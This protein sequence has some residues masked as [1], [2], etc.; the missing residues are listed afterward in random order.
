[1]DFDELIILVDAAIHENTQ[2]H[3]RDAE[4]LVLRGSWVGQGYEEIAEAHHYTTQYLRQ[5]VG[6]KLWKLLSQVIGEKVSKTSFRSALERYGRTH[7]EP[8]TQA[9]EQG[10]LFPTQPSEAARNAKIRV[11]APSQFPVQADWGDVIDVSV[12]YGRAEELKTLVQWVVGDRCRLI[13][14]L[15]MGGIGKTSLSVRL[16][17]QIQ[18]QFEFV[19]WRSLRNAPAFEDLLGS[20]IHFLSSQQSA[21]L[22][23]NQDAQ[24]AVLLDYL[25]QHRCLIVLD[26]WESVLM[27]G[28]AGA[29]N[30][31]YEAYGQLLRCVA[32]AQHQSCIMITSREKPK[33]LS[34]REGNTLPVRSLALNGLSQLDAFALF[35]D[36]GFVNIEPKALKEVLQHYGGNPLALKIVAAAVEDLADCNL[37]NLIP[38]LRRGTLQFEDINDLLARHFTRLSAAE[39]QFMYWMAVNRE[40][41]SIAEL[42]VDVLQDS[43]SLGLSGVVQS[44]RHRSLIE[45][46][47][48][49]YS[50]TPVVME[51]VTN[52]LIMGVCDEIL[53]QQQALI[54]TYALVK[55][56]A[57]DYVRQAQVQFVLRPILARLQDLLES[58]PRIEQC[59]KDVLAR[60]RADAPLQAGYVG[61]NILNLLRELGTDFKGLNCSY[62]AIWQAYLVDTNLSQVNFAHADLAR[63]AFT[64]VLSATLSVAFSP[65]G[66][67]FAMGSADDKVRVWQ[68]DEYKEVLICEG[69]SN[70]VCAVA[71]SPD[72]QTLASGSFDKTIKL[73]NLATGQCIKTLLGH[74]GW[75]W[76]IAFSPNGQTLVSGAD[77]HCIK[78]WDIASSKCLT[79]LEGHEST[80]WSLAYSPNGQT[81]A[82]SSADQTIRLWNLANGGSTELLQGRINRVRALAYSPDGAFLATGGIDCTVDIWDVE[83]GECLRSL[84]GHLQP[85]VC[86]AFTPTRKCDLEPSAQGIPVPLLATGSQDCTIRLWNIASGQC[87]KTLKGHPNGVWSVAFH[88]SGDLLV[89][90]SNDS[91]VKL[92][93]PNTGQSLR[94]LQGYSTGIK[95]LAFSPDGQLLASS[96]D[97]K[98]INLWSVASG[99]RQR[100]LEGHLSWVWC[101]VFSHNGQLLASSSNDNTIKLWQTSSWRPLKTLQGHL[102]LVFA[103]DFSPKGSILASASDDTTVR[104]WDIQSGECLKILPQGG[105]V[106]TV[107][108]SPDGQTL[109]CAHGERLVSLWDVQTGTCLR[110]LTGHTSLTFTTSFSPDGRLLASGSDDKTIRLWDVESGAC[111]QTLEDH[112]GSVWSVAFHQNGDTLVSGSNDTTVK[113]WSVSTGD[114]IQTLYG[115][116]REV[117]SVAFHPQT[118]EVFSA[119]QEGTIKRWDVATGQCLQTFQEDKPYDQMNIEGITGLTE[120]Q[121]S[122]LKTLGAIAG[123]TSSERSLF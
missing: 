116:E 69:H 98:K 118:L 84:K 107:S 93:N 53:S 6:P 73:W 123:D 52:R 5:D 59:L 18:E 89:S 74:E 41:V 7:L 44:L 30:Q 71:F 72:G 11:G 76:A 103:V 49:L 10:F 40:P 42:E 1:V 90:G 77:D 110:V 47:N 57:K 91:T 105:R 85:V 99:Q 104:L 20:L 58:K 112:S 70:W 38:Y 109:A 46:N 108:F 27:S 28:T 86:L 82:S 61:G 23:E 122:S 68:V 78:V 45:Q 75:V 111:L 67:Y 9:K 36:K 15:G 22:P 55:A 4:V 113:L 48:S 60:S 29:Y 2:R 96:G 119:A 100:T 35:A 66:T 31:G 92:W 120:A 34:Q 12:F 51:Y 80:V 3:L 81:L 13:S 63:S 88:P 24:L 94:T 37:V 14:L 97:N 50:L 17:Q 95:S 64:A 26:N 32:E 83:T 121:K 16:S 117:W 114:C 19:F 87:V 8:K 54:K 39:R 102:S 79:T 43:L 56:Q 62:L 33:G 115:H 25:Q 65:D 101:A 106:W 21:T